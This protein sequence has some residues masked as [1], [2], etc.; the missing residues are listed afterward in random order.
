MPVAAPPAR[1]EP[2]TAAP[3]AGAALTIEG[4]AN[5]RVGDEFQVVVHLSSAQA[6]THLRSQ[7]RFDSRALQLISATTGEIVPATAGSPSVD[8]RSGGA[9]L[10]VVASS[11]DPVQGEGGLMVL[12]F[13]A[14]G[15]RPSTSIAAQVSVLGSAGAAVG[16]G[17]AAPLNVTIQP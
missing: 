16:N 11:D 17:A 15:P 13:K 2:G 6:I 14:L 1:I 12:R 4:P 8:A 5:A 9:Q 3:T 7:V 10:D